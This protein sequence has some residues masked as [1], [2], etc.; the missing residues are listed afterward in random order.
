MALAGA[1]LTNVEPGRAESPQPSPVPIQVDQPVILKAEL[2]APDGRFRWL[3]HFR[4]P[5][6]P[7]TGLAL[8]GGG[9][10]GLAHIG[11]LE[12][13]WDDGF[14]PDVLAGTSMG[15]LIGSLIAA[16]NS[17]QEIERAFQDR[18][19]NQALAH[20]GRP[21]GA[22]VPLGPLDPSVALW[23]TGK[24]RGGKNL[25]W[26]GVVS[27]RVIL[28]ELYRLLARASA[29]SGG[30]LDQ[31]ALP[32][33]AVSV[34]L[35]AGEVYAPATGSLPALVRASIGLPIFPPVYLPGKALVDGGVL[36]N[37][38]VPTAKAMGPDVV[39]AVALSREGKSLLDPAPE[40]HT[41]SNVLGR[42][43][44]VAFS[45]HRQGFLD[46][47]D[48][49]VLIPTKEA[50]FTDFHD[51]LGL[52]VEAGKNAYGHHRRQML[53]AL[54]AKASDRRLFQVE[55][56]EAGAGLA[57]EVAAATAQRLLPDGKPRS[58]SALELEWELVRWLNSGDY[59]DGAWTL[60]P[61]GRLLLDLVPMSRVRE[62]DLICPSVLNRVFRDTPAR[63]IEQRMTPRAALAEL[64]RGIATLRGQGYLF[65]GITR[66]DWE[67]ESGKLTVAAEE[68]RVHQMLMTTLSLGESVP[69]EPKLC[70]KPGSPAKLDDLIEVAV[71]LTERGQITGIIAADVRRETDGRYTMDLMVD[72][73]PVWEAA[74]NGGFSEVG[75]VA[76]GRLGWPTRPGWSRWG[77][78]LQA[79][80]GTGGVI[81]AV[82]MTP[83]G[84]AARQL[85]ARFAGGRRLIPR[86]SAG[87]DLIGSHGFWFGA[88]MLGFRTRTGPL[89]YSEIG[90]QGRASEEQAFFGETASQGADLSL[91]AL[92]V[93]D[94]RDAGDRP[95]RGFQWTLGGTFPLG[96]KQRPWQAF[97]DCSLFLSLDHRKRWVLE[98]NGMIG[99]SGGKDPLPADR[100]FD[101]GGWEEAPR[102]VP[103]RG[104]TR[105][106]RR[107]ALIL[108]RD[109]G[110]IGGIYLTGGI[111]AATWKLDRRRIDTTL[112]DRAN[113]SSV[114]LELRTGRFGPLIIGLT[115]GDLRGG[116]V[117]LLFGVARFP[118]PG[119]V[120][121]MPGS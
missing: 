112:P 45:R 17:P 81:G 88:G 10:L 98:A 60:F 68:G 82:E 26:R 101:P 78:E 80:A 73:P 25:R 55:R 36:E 28:A 111:S 106:A 116:E 19:W 97:A 32:F 31:L 58:I 48:D 67:P 38:P 61:D 66:V 16:G 22:A 27:D 93:G 91:A 102:L 4:A 5:A 34:D 115:S 87:G 65:A 92:W 56:V 46:A 39:L 117:F 3:P 76:I 40:L 37:V 74:V 104:L 72:D 113:G 86:F 9:A 89:G 29:V 6:L 51:Q 100:W 108:R 54:E 14:R 75:P 110:M 2:V 99:H 23:T 57:P 7:K 107:G 44:D 70:P 63:V 109:L 12:A 52:L 103:G 59:S 121:R 69:V 53:V 94:R 15:G 83:P 84:A 119:P 30:D 96:V 120:P 79:A 49:V 20:Q 43:Y 1:L 11:F 18:D 21:H 71:R 41:F 42:T 35:I 13:A 85:F 50:L 118:A 105:Q 64:D 8:S 24:A 114:F 90:I 77:L 33:R 47:A 95:T 62:L